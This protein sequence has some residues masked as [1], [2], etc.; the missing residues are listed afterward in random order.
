MMQAGRWLLRIQMGTQR[1]RGRG[2]GSAVV[3]PEETKEPKMLGTDTGATKTVDDGPSSSLTPTLQS[4]ARH[5]FTMWRAK[6]SGK[7]LDRWA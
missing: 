6:F 7:A 1:R 3:P 4:P 5:S 2:Y